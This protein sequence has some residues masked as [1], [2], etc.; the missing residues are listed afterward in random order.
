[1]RLGMSHVNDIDIRDDRVVITSE[2]DRESRVI[3]TDGRDHSADGERSLRGHSIGRWE[4]PVLTVET[5]LFSEHRRGNG[6]RIPSGPDKRLTE[7]YEPTPDGSRLRLSYV[8]EDPEYFV[9]P[10]A[11]EF[12]WHYAPDF[13]LIPYSCDL[14]VARRYLELEQ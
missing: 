13:D 11:G 8:L 12:E 1:M 6:L 10:V 9:E 7:R 3:F 4:G 14:D 5:T 2:S